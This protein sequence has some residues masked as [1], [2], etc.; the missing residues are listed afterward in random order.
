MPAEGSMPS[1]RS[2]L[3]ATAAVGA[4]SVLGARLAVAADAI[5]S[6]PPSQGVKTMGTTKAAA[7]RPFTFRASDEALA[8][9]RRRINATRWPERERSRIDRRACSS[10][11]CR[12]LARYWATEHD[13]RKVRGEAQRPAAVRHRDR[14]A[15][16]PFHPRPFAS[17]RM[18]C[19]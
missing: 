13:W 12:Q 18:R 11:R 2:F 17:M 4:A 19:R 9:L 14:R 1:R 10:R 15:R 16:H 6:Q 7:V 8:D 3:T 5:R